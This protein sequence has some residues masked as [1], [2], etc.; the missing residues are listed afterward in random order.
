MS[1]IE[2]TDVEAVKEFLEADDAIEDE[3]L[4]TLVTEASDA[5]PRY[6]N[7]EFGDA[8]TKTRRFEASP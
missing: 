8:G 4:E 7:R 3:T 5:L 6:C 1:V 2:L